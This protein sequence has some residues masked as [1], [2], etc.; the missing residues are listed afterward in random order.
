MGGKERNDKATL[1][2]NWAV[3]TGHHGQQNGME[4]KRR[5]QMEDHTTR[6]TKAL[7]PKWFKTKR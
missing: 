1:T 2:L 7:T 4:T 5:G 6:K 3:F